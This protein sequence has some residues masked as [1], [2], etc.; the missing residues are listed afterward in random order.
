MLP[1]LYSIMFIHQTRYQVLILLFI[2]SPPLLFSLYRCPSLPFISTL[3]VIL[4]LIFLPFNLHRFL[5]N[6]KTLFL[7]FSRL[8]WFSP[9]SIASFSS[10]LCP[11]FHFR[12]LS[13]RELWLDKRKHGGR[14]G[15]QTGKKETVSWWTQWG[16]ACPISRMESRISYFSGSVTDICCWWDAG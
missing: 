5:L 6:P 15:G 3:R 11:P 7:S 1:S 8:F 2:R 13:S 14:G 4:T 9:L 10:I 16:S 12:P